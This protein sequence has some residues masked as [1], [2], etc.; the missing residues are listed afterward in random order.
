MRLPHER[1]RQMSKSSAVAQLPRPSLIRASATDAGNFSMRKAGR[2]VWSRKDYNEA[3]ST[4]NRLV[5]A[6]FGLEGEPE[7]M[8][9]VRFGFAEKLEQAGVLHLRQTYEQFKRA[10]NAAVVAA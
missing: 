3:A 8:A 4:H 1:E 10:F 7:Y 9:A 2:K 6:C 5:K